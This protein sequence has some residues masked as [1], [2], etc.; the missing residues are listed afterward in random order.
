M[1]KPT[2]NIH[3]SF[4]ETN[5]AYHAAEAYIFERTSKATKIRRPRPKPIQPPGRGKSRASTVM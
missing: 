2:T 3:R 5:G 1:K 4:G